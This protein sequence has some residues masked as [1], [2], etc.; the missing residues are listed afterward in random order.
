MTLSSHEPTVA[1]GRAT[2]STSRGGASRREQVLH[3]AEVL[4]AE[5]GYVETSLDL[6]A[7]RLGIKRQAIYYYFPSKDA[8]LVEIVVRT[9]GALKRAV[10]PTFDSDLSPSAKLEHVVRIHI[11]H[12]LRNSESFRIQFAEVP[13]MAPEFIQKVRR[14]EQAYVRQ[15][16]AVI[17]AGQREGEFR[18]GPAVPL[19]LMLIG[20][21]NATLEWFQPNRRL[22]ISA[23]AELGATLVLRGLLVRPPADGTPP[24]VG[25][26]N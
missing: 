16:V 8:I 17:E 9:G 3:E 18:P 5:R 7:T 12:V 6:V 15:V 20:M 2:A 21:C 11:D 10:M 4:F 14:D 26:P 22:S 24:D 19:A 23:A 25:S 1:A 13:R